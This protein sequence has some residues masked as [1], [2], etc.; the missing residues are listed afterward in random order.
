MLD[1][2]PSMSSSRIKVL[3][4]ILLAV[5]KKRMPF[6]KIERKQKFNNNMTPIVINQSLIL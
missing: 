6:V 2:V 4:I 5:F 3:I 1:Q